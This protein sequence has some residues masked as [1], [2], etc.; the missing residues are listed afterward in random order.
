MCNKVHLSFP[1]FKKLSKVSYNY[2]YDYFLIDIDSIIDDLLL[3]EYIGRVNEEFSL[4]IL[5]N[6]V[7]PLSYSVLRKNRLSIFKI[8]VNNLESK[9][10]VVE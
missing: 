9:E 4:A 3:L 7:A 8:M 5:Y 6:I 1:H 2:G 10:R